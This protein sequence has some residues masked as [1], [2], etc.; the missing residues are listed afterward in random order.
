MSYPKQVV[1]VL[2]IAALLCALHAQEFRSTIYGR[3]LDAQN[4]VMPNVRMVAVQQETHARTETVS[5]Q[6]GAFTLPFL[7][8]GTYEI[9]AEASGF[10]RYVHKGFAVS[11]NERKVL[12]IVMEIGTVAENVTVTAGA[13]LLDTASGSVGQVLTTEQ[14]EYVPLNGRNPFVMAHLWPGVTPNG[15]PVLTRPFDTGHSSDISIAG[16]PGQTNELLMDGGPNTTRDGR[17]AYNPPMDS[18]H[19]VKVEAFQTDAAF[20][21]T[22]GGTVN[23]VS[24]GGTN[25]YRGSVYWYNQVS[26][27][28]AA[29]FFGNR[30]GQPKPFALWNQFGLNAGGPVVLPKLLNGRDKLFFYYAFEGIR[31]PNPNP[32]AGT[33]PTE[34]MRRGDFSSLLRINANYQIYDPFS[35]VRE[36]ARVRRLPLTGNIIPQSRLSPVSLNFLQYWPL[37]NTPGGVDGRNNY[38]NNAAQRDNWDN[39]VGRL[40]YNISERHKMFLAVRKNDRNS[41]EQ[42]FYNNIARGRNFIR[43]IWS[44]MTDD[45]YTVTPTTVL[46]TRL[47]YTRFFEFRRL[48]SSGLDITK[49]GF[50]PQLAA[51]SSQLLLPRIDVS[52]F[53]QLGDSNANTTPYESFQIFVSLAKVVNR[54]SLKVGTDLRLFRESNYQ[55]AN[56]SGRYTFNTN[57][58][59]GPLDTAASSPLGQ[60]F[61]QFLYGLPTGGGWD[62][63]AFRTNQAG[64][65]A[66]FLQDDFRVGR[67]LTLNLGLRFEK[68]LPVTERFNRAVVGFDPSANTSVTAAARAAYAA[69]PIPEVPVS[70]FNPVGGLLFAGPGRRAPYETNL[71]I[72]PRLGF[73]WT[74]SALG[75]KTVF[76]GGAG[77]FY[78]DLGIASTIQTGFSQT[79]PIVPTLDGFL[80][81]YS[82]FANPY[83]DGILSPPGASRGVNTN[84]GIGI[85]AYNYNAN[86]PYS[87]RWNFG[88][89]HQLAQD[90]LLEMNYVGNRAVRLGVDRPFNVVPLQYLSRSPTRDQ[91]VINF[92][93]ANV[94][95]PFAGLLPGTNLNGN[96]IARSQLMGLYPQYTGVTI[97]AMNDGSSY[98]HMLHLKADKRFG[99]GLQFTAAYQFSKTIQRLNWLNEADM[100]LE[101]R[102]A[103]NDIPHRVVVSS[104]YEFPFGRGKRFASG[105][106]RLLNLMVGGWIGSGVFSWN[107]GFPLEWGNVIYLGGDLNP[108]PRN[109][110]R[111]F[112][113]SRFNTRA[114]DQLARNVRTFATT[115]GNLREDG[116]NNFDLSV[117]KNFPIRERLRVQ[118]RFEFFNALNHPLFGAP[119]LIPTS[120]T[121]G[122][123]QTQANQPRRIQTALRLIW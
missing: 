19:E 56:S 99:K 39:H 38:F 69:S 77:I 62:I 71:N 78:F 55:P 47:S 100:F 83:P 123:I 46:N 7:L 18:V 80:T 36:G 118:A 2:S 52:N 106:G 66:F 30:A 117:I 70:Q 112:D 33:V 86:N 43:D 92:L 74:P 48:L 41:F 102:I 94:Q 104:I 45:V 25:Q 114:A 59:R 32:F 6:D 20:G 85:G 53:A 119:D 23:L 103:S 76:R 27:L 89:Q 22:G 15:G 35:A 34:D 98:A 115:F 72:S 10:R 3:V 97:Q 122:A 13:P 63:Q 111:A 105:S 88:V 61:A 50:S 96:V 82:T 84:L 31:Q 65:M 12:E 5:G 68:E 49:L 121:F 1:H 73:A 81:P 95:N 64:Y 67:T 75:G 44:V 109:I 9:T 40:D 108:Q 8:P 91:G 93:A 54:H 26:R 79:T 57:W 29:P 107:R 51:Q 17:A 28:W 37:P 101:K 21:N 58:T 110:E 4:A 90:L 120:T 87:A 24:K 16:T 116:V 60:E 14:V 42:A 11:S 113:T